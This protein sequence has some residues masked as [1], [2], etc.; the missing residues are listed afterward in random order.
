MARI[1]LSQAGKS[2]QGHAAREVLGNRRSA[3]PLDVVGHARDSARLLA[4]TG[5]DHCKDWP[6]ARNS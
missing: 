6:S 3:M 4:M 5:V 2:F 1:Y